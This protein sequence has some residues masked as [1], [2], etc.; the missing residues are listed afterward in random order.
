[1][2]L[3]IT[4]DTVKTM[5]A[6]PPSL[7]DRPNFFN[8]WALWTEFAH[9]LRQ[10]PCPQST[11]NGWSSVVLTPN[12]YAL[13]CSKPFKNEMELKMLVPDFPPIFESNGTTIILYTREEMLKITAK[14][15]RKKT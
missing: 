13:I 4:Y 15:S 2:D 9:A 8:L 1:M 11:I 14:F 7:G 6:N 12:M 3:V 5:V 10:I